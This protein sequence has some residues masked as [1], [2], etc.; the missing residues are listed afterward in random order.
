L[1]RLS[2]RDVRSLSPA[3]HLSQSDRDPPAKRNHHRL[4]GI[5]MDEEA[6]S[7]T[8]SVLAISEP[9]NRRSAYLTPIREKLPLIRKLAVGDL[10]CPTGRYAGQRGEL[11]RGNLLRSYRCPAGDYGYTILKKFLMLESRDGLRA[12]MS[13]PA[14]RPDVCTCARARRQSVKDKTPGSDEL[15][16]FG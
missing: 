11:A 1:N 9:P 16:I 6:G 2:G 4:P 13:A 14:S 3:H 7:R 8:R 5:P 10:P 15:G 12:R